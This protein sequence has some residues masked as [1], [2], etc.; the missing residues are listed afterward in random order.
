M[1]G[2]G[3]ATGRAKV[4]G[5]TAAVAV[6]LLGAVLLPRAL[7]GGRA[8]HDPVRLPP[9]TPR[10]AG[11][12][13]TWA[14]GSTIHYGEQTFDLSPWL[15]RSMLRTSYGFVVEVSETWGFDVP[16][17]TK[18]YDGSTLTDLPGDI[19]SSEVSPDGRYVG[20]MDFD[21]PETGNGQVAEAVVV[22]LRTGE[23]LVRTHEGMESGSDV[24]TDE[25]Y[26]EQSP[27]F[28]GFDGDAGYWR[29]VEGRR[30]R[31]DLAS[32]DTEDLGERGPD[33]PFDVRLGLSGRGWDAH[34]HDGPAEASIVTGFLSPDRRWLF[35]TE[36]T[37]KAPVEDAES[38]RDVTPDYGYDWVF[39]GG[40]RDV[41]TYY[42]LARRH[43]SG[44][45]APRPDGTR[46]V[47]LSCSLPSGPCREVTE[48]SDINTLVFPVGLRA[49]S[50][51]L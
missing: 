47:L 11:D 12:E 24:D 37:G 16:T 10:F 36:Q 30:W 34:L 43:Y 41:D 4:L 13:V 19:R 40:W 1:T 35:R 50:E 51:G 25:L 29:D 33:E 49:L 27:E 48:V 18:L 5:A 39:F 23:E 6:L 45:I 22:D 17:R 46:G 15:V 20:W 44:A 38:G 8:A 9:G 28:L 2:G 7:G 21:G 31:L 32:G 3:T 14:Q 42:V 26:A